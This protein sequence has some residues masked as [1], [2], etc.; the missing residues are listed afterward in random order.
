MSVRL[1]LDASQIV[2]SCAISNDMGIIASASLEKPIENFPI[3]IRNV[4][5]CAKLSMS[6]IDEIVV[7]IGPGSQTGIR[8][9]VV[10]GNALALALDIPISGVLCTDAAA[11][12]SESKG[13]YHVAISAGRRRW[14][15]EEYFYDNGI[16]KRLDA[17]K[18]VDDLPNQLYPVFCVDDVAGKN[19]AVGVLMVA[20]K[21]RHLISQSMLNEIRPYEVVE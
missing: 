15:I 3:L 5:S 14:F 18:L 11:I 12:L 7:C 20:E 21:Q 9:A 10:F 6:D 4:L 2:A 17:M 13:L 1:G 19:C 8:T 16:L